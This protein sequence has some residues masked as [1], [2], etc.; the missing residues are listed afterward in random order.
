MPPLITE[1]RVE[2]GREEGEDC[3]ILCEA[4][5]FV[6]RKMKTMFWKAKK[7]DSPRRVEADMAVNGGLAVEEREVARIFGEKAGFCIGDEG[8]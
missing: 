2:N 1:V 8:I 4:A 6:D 3:Q 7:V 5:K